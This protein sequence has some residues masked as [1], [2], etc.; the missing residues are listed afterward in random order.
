MG[1]TILPSS[2]AFGNPAGHPVKQEDKEQVCKNEKRKQNQYY[3][4]YFFIPVL[5]KFSLIIRYA[6]NP[7]MKFFCRYTLE[8]GIT[9]I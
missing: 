9:D 5:L 8:Q 6:L 4:Q 3:F 1:L 7:F 2:S